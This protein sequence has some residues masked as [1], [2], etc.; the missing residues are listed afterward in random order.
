[1]PPPL[2]RKTDVVKS[3]RFSPALKASLSRFEP[4]KTSLRLLRSEKF[5][6]LCDQLVG[7]GA[8]YC[9][10]ILNRLTA[11]CGT[12]EAVH[13]DLKEETR[14]FSVVV[15]HFS[16]NTGLGYRHC[17]ILLGLKWCVA[18]YGQLHCY[19]TS[20]FHICQHIF[21]DQHVFFGGEGT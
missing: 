19:Y 21:Q 7:I 10:S 14:S 4:Y 18:L 6:E 2:P 8:V 20:F 17:R 9:T 1:M 5:V 16:D 3:L 11:R 13:T 12:T 15:E